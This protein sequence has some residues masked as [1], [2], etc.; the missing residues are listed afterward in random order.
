[1]IF[2]RSLQ[3]FCGLKAIA[4]YLNLLLPETKS[5]ASP[6]YSGRGHPKRTSPRWGRI[7]EQRTWR[8]ASTLKE[9]MGREY[10]PDEEGKTKSLASPY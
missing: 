5:L 7:K 4:S 6:Y 2:D 10:L 9:G 8:A 1:M 3:H